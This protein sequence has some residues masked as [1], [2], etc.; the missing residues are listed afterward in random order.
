LVLLLGLSSCATYYQKNNELMKS[1]YSEN[2]EKANKLLENDVKWEKKGRDKLLF[3]LNKASV[4]WMQGKYAESNSYFAKADILI[5]DY[6][7]NYLRSFVGLL[8]NPMLTV[9]G[10]EGF[11]QI[12]LHYFT[13]LNYLSLN[14]LD[15]AL[16]EC[17]RMQIKL[18]KITDASK[19]ENKYKRDAFAHN[20]LGMIYDAQ[21][22][23]NNAFIAYRNAYEI[24]RDDY[25]PQFATA[26]P[27]Q[28][29]KDII[30]TAY[31]T[32]F[33][34][35]VQFYENKFSM[36]YEVQP[37]NSGTVLFL[38]NN[39]YGPIKDEVSFNFTII[40]AANGYV[41]FYNL[42]LNMN[43]PFYVGKEE[44]RKGLADL[45]IVRVAFPRYISRVPVFGKGEIVDSLGKVYK[46]EMAEDINAI[47]FKSL[48]DRMF[49]EISEGVLRLAMKQLAEQRLRKENEN[50]GFALGILNALTEK[51][52]TRNW[53]LLPYSISYTRINL[54]E[55]KHNLKLIADEKTTRSLKEFPISVE[56][57]KK[58]VSFKSIQTMKFSGFANKDGSIR[59]R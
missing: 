53:Q 36:K 32:S 48:Q 45:K 46:L 5:E 58:E 44:D 7:K 40:P 2:Y 57:N 27:N 22:D 25:L 23:Y 16:I 30:R 15:E 41:N 17:K 54:S 49:R 55:G 35:E 37:N 50:A 51:A 42:E 10:G 6:N 52:D 26:I 14:K 8:S 28:L 21:G 31:L 19:G 4:L 33:K 39:G 24:Y 34:D 20:L 13:T 9:Y 1:V 11:E 47:A 29:K 38:W 3:Y 12:L 59:M 56:V 43:I 18:Q